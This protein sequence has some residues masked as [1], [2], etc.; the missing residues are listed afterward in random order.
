MVQDVSQR[1]N[2][3]D[4]VLIAP[5]TTPEAI[6]GTLAECG[7]VMRLERFPVTTHLLSLTFMT[8]VESR[9]T[10]TPPSRGGVMPGSSV[11]EL[12]ESL[13]R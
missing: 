1:W 6:A 12:V 13:T 10:V 8:D 2:R 4:G 11:S 5:N 3:V 7:V 9:V